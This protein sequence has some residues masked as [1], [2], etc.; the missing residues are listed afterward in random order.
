MYLRG[1]AESRD[2][3]YFKVKLIRMAIVHT[4]ALKAEY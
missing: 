4:K 3:T 2:L 1:K